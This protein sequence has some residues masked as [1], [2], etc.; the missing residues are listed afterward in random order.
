[1]TAEQFAYWLQGF[2][3][4]N[5]GKLPSAAQWKSIKEH[6]GEVFA[7]V[8]PPMRD[9]VVDPLKPPSEKTSKQFESLA[10]R[11]HFGRDTLIC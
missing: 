8:T 5:G 7:K 11:V 9:D 3:E 2:V 1:M 4:L 10:R 6:L